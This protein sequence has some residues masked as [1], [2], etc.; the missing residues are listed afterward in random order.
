MPSIANHLRLYDNFLPDNV[1]D[2]FSTRG[3]DSFPLQWFKLRRTNTKEVKSQSFPFTIR[4]DGG[5]IPQV[6]DDTSDKLEMNFLYMGDHVKDCECMYCHMRKLFENYGP[7][8]VKDMKI[9]EDFISVYR[10]G[11]FLG[12]HTDKVA[13]RKWAFTYTLTKNWKPEWGGILNVQCPETEQ[14]YAFPPEYNRLILMEVG[15]VHPNGKQGLNHFVSE[16]SAT[17]PRNR[18]TY[19]GWWG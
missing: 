17:A 2:D 15:T 7:E 13:G 12:Q 4:G 18:I 14:W 11:D 8:E 16:V 10:P 9:L 19:S 5:R 3:V 1:A 6:P